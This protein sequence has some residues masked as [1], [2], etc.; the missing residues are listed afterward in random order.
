MDCPSENTLLSFLDGGLDAAAQERLDAHAASCGECRAVLSQLGKSSL[1]ATAVSRPSGPPRPSQPEPERLESGA[2]L[3]E[4]YRIVRFIAAGG[5]GE[6]YEAQDLELGA[7]VALK[8]IRPDVVSDPR[9]IERFKR[10]IHLARRVTHPNVC[11][12]FDVGFLPRDAERSRAGVA[13]GRVPFLTMELLVGESLAE[14]LARAVRL[15]PDEALPIAEQ[16]AEAL[17]AAH[18]AG[19]V[20]RDF[21]SAN[22]MLVAGRSGRDPAPRAVVTDFG[23]ARASDGLDLARTASG[24][25]AIVGSP[26]YMAPEQLQ[27]VEVT[28]AADIYAYGVVLY[29]MVTGRL[30]FEG[31]TALLVALRRLEHPPTPPTHW[32]PD[33]PEPWERVLLR[34]LEREPSARFAS[35]M[36]AYEALRRARSTRSDSARRSSEEAAFAL[37]PTEYQS[38]ELPLRRARTRGLRGLGAAALTLALGVAATGW[39]RSRGSDRARAP[40][41]AASLASPQGVPAAIPADPPPAPRPP[42]PAPAPTETVLVRSQPSGAAVFLGGQRVATTPAAIRVVIPQEVTLKL[43]GHVPVRQRLVAPGTVTV[44]LIAGPPGSGLPPKAQPRQRLLDE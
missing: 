13:T 4:R 11:R 15:T 31:A 36:E 8:R 26:L 40:N 1:V 14:R 17:S 20:H 41:V 30:P 3:A 28:A 33:L 9:A 24:E 42:A 44:R 12:I 21:K 16:L 35:V 23:V 2:L 29:E 6:V 32:V 37:A 43:A 19:V 38:G 5:M 39:L 22:I 7:R 34:C 18:A 10:E 27:G 25:R